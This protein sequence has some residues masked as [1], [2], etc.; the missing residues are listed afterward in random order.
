[1][2]KVGETL[3]AVP[4]ISEA[5]SDMD[6]D[7]SRRF[8]RELVLEAEESFFDTLFLRIWEINHTFWFEIT[9]CYNGIVT[10]AILEV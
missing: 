9:V 7:V 6:S 3:R 10:G 5:F 8:W 4:R 1:M 2:S